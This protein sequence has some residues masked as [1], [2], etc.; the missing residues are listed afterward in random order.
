MAINYLNNWSSTEQSDAKQQALRN[1][2]K[3]DQQNKGKKFYPVP[4]PSG[5]RGTY[6]LKEIQ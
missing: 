5:I 3:F 2:R 1:K 4:H 6:I